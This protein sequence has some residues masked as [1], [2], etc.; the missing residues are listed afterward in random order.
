MLVRQALLVL[1]LFPQNRLNRCMHRKYSPRVGGETRSE[2]HVC[3]SVCVFVA[4]CLMTSHSILR[5][6]LQFFV[7]FRFV[8]VPFFFPSETIHTYVSACITRLSLSLAQS[9]RRSRV[10]QIIDRDNGTQRSII[11]LS[12]SSC[13]RTDSS[14]PTNSIK[15]CLLCWPLG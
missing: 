6:S 3:V 13:P 12:V 4:V 11:R 9:R 5:A 1:V 7:S 8:S 15:N 2:W 14:D 10:D